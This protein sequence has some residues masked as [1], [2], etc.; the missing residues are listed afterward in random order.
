VTAELAKARAGHVL[1]L[2]LLAAALL[3]AA[4]LG[5][6]RWLF[7]GLAPGSGGIGTV[8]G[9]ILDLTFVACVAALLLVG[10]CL[11]LFAAL[12]RGRLK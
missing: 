10:A 8:A 12:R 2:G 9:S 11:L 4:A 1:V 6:L 5:A 7:A 3:F